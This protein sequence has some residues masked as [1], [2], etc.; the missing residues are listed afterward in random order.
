MTAK[1]SLIVP[2]YRRETLLCQTL[3]DALAL[4]WSNYE[5]IVVDQTER[6]TPDTEAYLAGVRH[7]IVYLHHRPPSVV[8]ALNRGVAAA[9][10]E[11]VLFLD[12]DI[13]LPDRRLIAQHVAN[14][15]DTSI[16]G[17]AGRV[18]DAERPLTGHF[19]SRS[20]NPVWGF[21]HSG[22][23][24]DTRC[25]VTT[26]PGANASF[27]REVLV[28]VG[29]VDERFIGNAFRWENDLCLRVRAAGYH[30]IYDPRPM[31]HHF[32][33]SPGGN[34]NHHLH[35]RSAGSHRWYRDF[36]HN[37]V[38][39]SLKHMP[40]RSLTPLIWRLYRSHVLNGP[41]GSEGVSFLVARHRAMLE[42][43]I[44]GRRTYRVWRRHWAGHAPAD[45]APT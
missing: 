19:D 30:V 41:Y 16:G 37:H 7:R 14:Y 25:E 44:A 43:V 22:W 2:T 24:H 4:E 13:R 8:V 20:Q 3:S 21:F 28:A 29:G 12:D 26:A 1:V 39:V 42:G 18:L 6:H 9:D 5:I 35:G 45:V 36:F 10:G 34:E 17:V 11:I 40:R 38:Y 32:Y 27:R 15:A 31:V 23:T 33:R